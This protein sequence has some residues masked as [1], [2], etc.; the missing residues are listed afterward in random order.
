MD[1]DSYRPSNSSGLNPMDYSQ[2]HGLNDNY[3]KPIATT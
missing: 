2:L 3:R 1:N